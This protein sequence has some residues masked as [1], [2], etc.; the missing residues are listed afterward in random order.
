M[1]A[2]TPS[3]GEK[4]PRV[5]SPMVIS[6]SCR[7]SLLKGRP[8]GVS[9]VSPSPVELTRPASERKNSVEADRAVGNPFAMP[10]D[11][12][13]FAMRDE[14]RKRKD[15]VRSNEPTSDRLG[16]KEAL[17][18]P[19]PHERDMGHSCICVVKRDSSSS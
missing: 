12:E 11:E 10:S 9:A 14:E 13:V 15:E 6:Y 17:Y 19:C 7:R 18:S 3:R 8:A 2:K 1:S 16:T 5:R 4:P